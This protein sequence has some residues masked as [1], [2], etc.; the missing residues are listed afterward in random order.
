VLA[1]GGKEL[2]FLSG[3]SDAPAYALLAS[4]LLHHRG[5]TYSGEPT[6]FR[7][8][9]YPILLAA[10]TLLF[11]RFNVAATRC[12]QFFVCLATAWMCGRSAKVLFGAQAEKPTFLLA[13]ALP[14]QLFASAQIL[15][16]CMATF[17]VALFFYY[18]VCQLKFPSSKSEIGMGLA[19]A[20]GTYL[21]FN[22]AALP[23][24]A[25]LVAIR[26]K[27]QRRWIALAYTMFLPLVLLSPWLIR[28]MVV[29]NR[30]VLFS[31]QSGYNALQGILTPAGRTQPG[32]STRLRQA[33]G[34]VMSDLETN[35]KSRLSLPSEAALNKQ[36]IGIASGL[37]KAEGWHAVPLL[38]R[39]VA[40]F[41]L[42]T[43]QILDT[44]SFPFSIRIVRFL[45]AITYWII[46]ATAL[47]GWRQLHRKWPLAANALFTY[48]LVYTVLHLPLVMSTRIRF[49]LMDPLVAILGGGVLS[50]KVSPETRSDRELSVNLTN[51][52]RLSPD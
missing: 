25:G 29:F 8:S 1:A 39:K 41:W 46:L 40:D 52:P 32:D 6:A 5:Y 37:W 14:T 4:N 13:L 33:V 9:G 19:T 27:G 36:C 18:F 44:K 23:L 2:T 38:S 26:H 21:R 43:D 42:S 49:P 12:V 51:L 50:L 24:I 34:W 47:V 45:G 11:G 17:F 28:N 3:G 20:V 16:E 15:T 35:D 30:T 22:A 10:M 31:T 7:P 48:A